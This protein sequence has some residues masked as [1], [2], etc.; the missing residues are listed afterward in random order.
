MKSIQSIL[1]TFSSLPASAIATH[2]NDALAE[3]AA[4]VVTA[5]PGAGKSTLLPLTILAAL[6]EQGD[7]TSR[8]LMLE[9]RR[10]AARQVAERMAEMLGE[11]VG[12][13]VGYR[14]RFET[15]VSPAT[16]IE[17]LTE[18]IL[19]RMLVSDP[20]LD[21]VAMVLFDEFHERSLASDVAL[22]L[23]RQA[24]DILRPD[25]RL[26]I[27]SATI[28]ATE[29]CKT[30]H[31]PLIE[32][33]G[34]MHPVAMERFD[35]EAT[36]QNAAETTAR[37][38]IRAYRET[39]GSILAFLPGQGEILRC[40]ELLGEA[41]SPTPVL[42]LYGML[43][44]EEQRR[45]IMP[46]RNGERKVVIA[47]PIAETSLTIQGITCV[48]DSGLYRTMAFDPRTGL[49]HMETR[50]IS[51]DMA[52]QRMG[53]AGRLAPGTCYRLWSTATEHRMAEHRQPEILTADLSSTVLD[54]ATWGES[55]PLAL[56][57]LTPPTTAAIAQAQR[58]LTTLQ[59]LH[60]NKVSELGKRMSALPCHPRIARMI[61]CA[62]NEEDKS[63]ACNI[64]AILER[65]SNSKTATTADFT[66]QRP[67]A[68]IAQE[69]CRMAHVKKYVGSPSPYAVGALL[70]SA[71][72]ER[73]GMAL[74]TPGRFRLASGDEA[75]VDK[76][77][78][79]AACDAIAVA[80]VNS[81][82]GR[83]FL[84]APLHLSDITGLADEVEHVAW[85]KNKGGIVAQRERRIGVHVLSVSPMHD[86]PQSAIEHILCDTVKRDGVSLLDWTDE[87]Q[88]LQRRIAAV[89]EWHPE[90]ELPDLT[91]DHV[92]ATAEEWLPLW[93]SNGSKLRTTAAE[94]KRLPLAEALWGM[95][96]YDQ[97]Q[98]VDRLAPTH[99][100]VPT[101]S[102]IRIDYRQGAEAPV[103]SVRLQE[104][105]GLTDTPRVDD[106][107]RPVLMELLSPGFKPV[108]LTQDLHSFWTNAYFDVRKDLRRRYPKHSWPENPL[109]AQAVRGVKRRE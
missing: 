100:T 75:F 97:Q 26:V 92:L 41:L 27:M 106:G 8:I 53:R 19:T 33:E 57:W 30:L 44:N 16:R 76:D 6:T 62:K 98:T 103:L 54:I 23:A 25:L 96:T 70:A 2:V 88:R 18:G 58:T 36:P 73:I 102:R 12:Q 7:T 69:Y 66:S 43:S 72:P 89:S 82:G 56:P 108:Q 31:A 29:I 71:Y 79:I 42:P 20:T 14:I 3:H 5:P 49:E 81:N 17:V 63:L 51:L 38:I 52:T 77:D 39:S 65:P 45:A 101:G 15:R 13:T 34:R 84:A 46:C 28:D 64:A 86:V 109:E 94:L 22:A 83:I 4:L 10:L 93:L 40:I 11:E 87:V 85:D 55:N 50:R 60:N 59:A 32:S 61:L 74:T 99:I 95:L 48:V 47:T 68:R 37:A 80:S 1:D 78:A 90:L 9:P 21:G 104:C 67:D 107:K 91:T 35:E 24:Q 105:F